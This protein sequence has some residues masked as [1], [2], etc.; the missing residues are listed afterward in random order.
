MPSGRKRYPLKF[1]NPSKK[2]FGELF[3][4]QK[5]FPVKKNTT[6]RI[7]KG[8]PTVRVSYGRAHGKAVEAE[9]PAPLCMR[10]DPHLHLLS[11]SRLGPSTTVVLELMFG[12]QGKLSPY[13]VGN[14]AIL[15]GGPGLPICDLH[16]LIWLTGN[17]ELHFVTSC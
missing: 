3:C 16:M 13:A 7:E 5:K 4:L 17:T 12:Y 2:F 10:L 11:G 8:L 9:E 6:P 1:F 14:V 15:L